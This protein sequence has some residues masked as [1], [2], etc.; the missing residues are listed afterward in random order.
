M[1]TVGYGSVHVRLVAADQDRLLA[2]AVRGFARSHPV[3]C[4]IVLLAAELK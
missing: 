1:I 3:T 2:S 4:D